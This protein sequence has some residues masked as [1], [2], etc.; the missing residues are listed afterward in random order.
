MDKLFEIKNL[1]TFFHTEAGTVKAVNDVSFDIYK[2]EVLGIVGESGSGKSVTSLSINRLIPNPPGEIVSGKIIYDGKNLLDLSYEEMRGYRGRHISMIFQEPMTSLNPVLRVGVQMNEV[3][4]EHDGISEE[5][6][7]KKSI[8]MLDAVGIPEPERRINDYPHQFSGGMR[9]RIMIAMALQCN[10]SL[11]I[12]DEPTTALDVTIQAQILDLMMELKDSRN[13][14]AILLITHDLAVIAETCDRV[15]VMYG[16]VIQEI[17]T[18]EELF[19]NPIHPYTKA[20]MESIPK[21]DKKSKRLKALKGMVPSILEL[22][23]GCKL[24]SRF[25]PEECACGGTKVE[26]ELTEVEKGHFARI[27]T[28]MLKS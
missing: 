27:N 23:D 15:I 7:T 18:I 2:G 14:A 10:P 6:A 5:E 25:E 19:K 1:K 9:Q 22:G 8:K 11:L 24:C 4:V 16:G 13:D 3:L 28:E 12:A 20:L 21:I 17:A 26:P